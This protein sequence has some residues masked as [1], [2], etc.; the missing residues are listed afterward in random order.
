M[1]VLSPPSPHNEETKLYY[2]LGRVS[3]DTH[4]TKRI[5]HSRLFSICFELLRRIRLL[6][7]RR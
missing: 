3:P 1:I 5:F 7:D 6:L 2:T 4:L